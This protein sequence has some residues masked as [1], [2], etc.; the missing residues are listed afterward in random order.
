MRTKKHRE[1]SVLNGNLHT[2]Q[3]IYTKIQRYIFNRNSLTV[4]S[5]ENALEQA[6]QST[7]A[8][9]SHELSL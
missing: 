7:N 5:Y 6:L 1:M 2:V 4:T 3:I 8:T 9:R